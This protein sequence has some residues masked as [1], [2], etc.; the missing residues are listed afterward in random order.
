MVDTVGKMRKAI[1]RWTEHVL[2]REEEEAARIAREL[3]TEGYRGRGRTKWR[4]E[5]VAKADMKKG[6]VEDARDRRRWRTRTRVA[7]PPQN[8][9]G[10]MAT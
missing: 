5:D 6:L 4:W 10:V 9:L 3:E 7:D 8:S 1:L 2:R